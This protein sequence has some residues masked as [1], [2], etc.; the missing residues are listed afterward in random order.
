MTA[1]VGVLNKHGAAIAA[2]S[3]VTIGGKK[4][5]NSANKV[6]TLSKYE[7]VAIAVYNN[8][9]L[10]TTPWEIVIKEYRKQLKDRHFDKLIQYIADFFN[11]L[12][13]RNYFTSTKSQ[14]A[15]LKREFLLSIEIEISAIKD[16]GVVKKEDLQA[17]L[18]SKIE[19]EI[20][21]V[22]MHSRSNFFGNDMTYS[23]FII[24]AKEPLKQVID[25]IKNKYQIEIP[26]T[27]FSFFMYRL[28][29]LLQLIRNMSGLVF[30]GYGDKECYPSLYNYECC[31]VVDNDLSFYEKEQERMIIGDNNGACISPFAQ[32]DVVQTF[33][34]GVNPGLKDIF[35]RA[36]LSSVKSTI[37][38]MMKKIAHIS[39]DS[40]KILYGLKSDK[41]FLAGQLRSFNEQYNELAKE[42]YISPFVNSVISLEKDDLADLAE[43]L[44]KL[45]SLRRKISPDQTTVGGP[46]DVMVI[47]KGD[48]IV[49]IK[50]KHY[51]KPEL[52]PN[53]FETYLKH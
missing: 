7:P 44:V 12:K 42:E 27:S 31:S 37:D 4:V 32:V 35:Q 3:A 6:F 9:D 24:F 41:N 46:I 11:F 47:S 25:E 39:P 5:F 16:Q 23:R 8:S 20:V 43:S 15:Y 51:F 13:K 53:F 50:R 36:F 21:D 2:D 48:G 28:F 38:V 33:V 29:V 22:D 52:N 17:R 10:I 1:I 19:N 14:H 49:W 45:T 26:N 30:V 34:R 18:L 40:E